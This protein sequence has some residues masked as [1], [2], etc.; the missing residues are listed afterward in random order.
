VATFEANLSTLPGAQGDPKTMVW[1]SGQPEA[2][3]ACRANLRDPAEVMPAYV[4]W[5]KARFLSIPGRLRF[6]SAAESAGGMAGM[7]L[8]LHRFPHTV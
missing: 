5:M 2:W 3:V 7:S 6:K 8:T 4:V 1:W